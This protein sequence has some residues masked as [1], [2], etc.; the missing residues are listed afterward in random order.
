MRP[1]RKRRELSFNNLLSKNSPFSWRSL[2]AFIIITIISTT[3][4]GFGKLTSN[5]WIQLMQWLGGFFI[6]GEAARKFAGAKS[7]EAKDTPAE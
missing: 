4:L 5:D 1:A 3:L 6:T 7:D 2:F